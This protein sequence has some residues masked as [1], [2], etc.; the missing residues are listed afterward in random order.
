MTLPP[1][2]LAPA[3]RRRVLVALAALAAAGSLPG[4]PRAQTPTAPA[5]ATR[6]IPSTGENLP[7]VGLGTW[8][9]FNVGNDRGLRE[10]SLAVLRAFFEGGGRMIDSSPMYGSSQE[11]VGAGLERLGHPR[12]LFA[13][14]KVWIGSGARGP[15]QIE[16]SRRLWRIPRF[17]LLQV[18]NLLAWQEHLPTLIA[19]KREGRL[20]YVG[21]TTSE[22]RRHR[23]FE[24]L[25]REHPLDFVQFSYNAL[26]REAE[27]RLLPLAQD[28]G[29]AVIVNRPFRQ[30]DLT[31]ALA[32]HPLPGWAGELGCRSWA[33]VLLKFIL[34]HPAVTCAI[35]ATSSVAHVR[36][37]LAAGHGPLPDAALRKRIVSQVEKLA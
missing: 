24:Q 25:M 18:H 8:I 7:S 28:R 22:G 11:V 1:P 3:S 33:Q 30:G 16:E 20:G 4:V 36:E 21:I 14:D 5:P 23:E 29:I 2:P 6:P 34:A 32:R 15:G 19:M 37:N 35:P 13:A 12:T 27:E 26:D 31:R 17:D 9:T 10:Q